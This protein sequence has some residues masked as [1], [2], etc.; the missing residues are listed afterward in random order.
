MSLPWRELLLLAILLAATLAAYEPAW[1]GGVLW[2]DAGHIT[3]VDLRPIDGLRRIWVDLAAT[4]QYY[5]LVHS[6]F[7]LL[8]RVCGDDTLGYHLVSIG[9]HALAAFLVAVILRRLK[10][11]W[12]WLAAL[13]FALHPVHVESVAW[14]TELKNTQSGVLFLASALAYLHFD[15][16]RR[17]STYGLAAGL[18]VMAL[19]SKTVTATLPVLLLV[20]F[21]WRRGQ[22]N[23]RRDVLPMT[24]LIVVGVAF[25]ALTGWTERALIGASGTEFQLTFIERCR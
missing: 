20:V 16:S 24:P 14:I 19:L 8:Y 21:W 15:E 11:P 18:F 4:Q 22:V 3:R 9:L 13:I 12:P 6:T 2:D 25:G 5:P 17:K 1:R 7:W 23:L 10:V